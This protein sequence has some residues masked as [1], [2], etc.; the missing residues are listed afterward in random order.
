MGSN[1]MTPTEKEIEHF[2]TSNKECIGC[3]RHG[4]DVMLSYKPKNK[5][6]IT[7]LSPA[8]EVFDKFKHLGIDKGVL[9]SIIEESQ[10]T[11][12]KEVPN[13]GYDI[14][15]LFMTNKQAEDLANDLIRTVQNNKK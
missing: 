14:I 7:Q 9:M 2:V 12:T 15:D 4:K 8:N 6:T 13:G 11:H 10:K 1:L 3:K 5:G